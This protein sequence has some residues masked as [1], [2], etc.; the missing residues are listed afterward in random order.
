MINWILFGLIWLVTVNYFL[1]RK[2]KKAIALG[3][4]DTEKNSIK[5]LAKPEKTWWDEFK[6]TASPFIGG[7]VLG[8]ICTSSFILLGML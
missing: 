2:A 3:I 7:F 8:A 6:E 1:N 4:V 5:W